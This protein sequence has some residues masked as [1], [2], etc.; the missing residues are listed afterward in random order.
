[1]GVNWRMEAY[2]DELLAEIAKREL[3][4]GWELVMEVLKLRPAGRR[5]GAPARVQLR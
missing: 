5:R 3:A 4:E 2:E 1:M